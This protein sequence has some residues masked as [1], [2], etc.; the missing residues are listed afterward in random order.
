[1]IET[2][3]TY[4]DVSRETFVVVEALFERFHPILEDYLEQLKGW[5]RSINLVSRNID[6]DLLR[7]HLRHSL[8]PSILPEFRQAKNI[9]DAGSGG[10]LP[11]L[12]LSLCFPGKQFI[13][14]DISQKKTTV[15]DHIRREMHLPNVKVGHYPVS[16]YPSAIPDIDCIVS[17]HAFKTGSLLKDIEVGTWDTLILLKGSDFIEEL[18][19]LPYPVA[20]DCYNLQTGT[21]NPFYKGKVLLNIRRI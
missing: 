12:P 3:V 1:M 8:F 6:D 13:L 7:E 9:L 16:E 19:D 2:Q 21:N 14:N 18:H 5:N 17:K 10:G 20:I 4:H 11:G 15:L